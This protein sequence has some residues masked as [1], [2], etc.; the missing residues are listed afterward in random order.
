[1]EKAQKP[2]ARIARLNIRLTKEEMDMIIKK[3]TK[4]FHGNKTRFLVEAA[5][6]Y[7]DTAKA[8]AYMNIKKY[9]DIF[10]KIKIE[11]SRQGN[12][13]NQIAHQ[14]NTMASEQGNRPIANALEH[15]I[16][17]NVHPLLAKI[18]SNQKDFNKQV[19]D[20]LDEIIKSV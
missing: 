13:L 1:M 14:L 12:N 8:Q 6:S 20:V 15:Y 11:L 9:S 7:N 2:L 18:N 10:N 5:H 19:S 17:N 3:S 16:I 4:C